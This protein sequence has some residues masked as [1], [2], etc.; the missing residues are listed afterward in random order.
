M[1]HHGMKFLR[2]RLVDFPLP[3]RWQ[4]E[5]YFLNL[6]LCLLQ[7]MRKPQQNLLRLIS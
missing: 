3:L 2:S 5:V 6:T 7:K 1:D 4:D